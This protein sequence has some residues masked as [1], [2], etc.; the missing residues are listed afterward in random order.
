M[1]EIRRKS[2]YKSYPEFILNEKQ[3]RDLMSVLE[4]APK[5][6]SASIEINPKDIAA[7][8]VGMEAR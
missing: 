8:I 2:G 3:I 6:P 4:G 1:N 5:M 7:K